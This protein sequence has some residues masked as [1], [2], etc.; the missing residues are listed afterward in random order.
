MESCEISSQPNPV[1]QN[2]TLLIRYF[3]QKD[4]CTILQFFLEQCLGGNYRHR[5]IR[6]FMHV[7]LCSV[8]RCCSC[9]CC[10][11]CLCACVRVCVCSPV[12]LMQC[13]HLN[14]IILCLFGYV[15]EQ[16]Y[17]YLYCLAPCEPRYNNVM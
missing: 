14:I 10:C 6:C 8:C 17:T 4:A 11:V 3:Q 16:K 13:L 1:E 5:Y 12:L 15:A 2:Q 7:Q 9:C